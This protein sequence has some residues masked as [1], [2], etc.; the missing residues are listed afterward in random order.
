[1]NIDKEKNNLIFA[2]DIGTRSLIG[3]VGFYDNDHFHILDS[4]MIFHKERAMYD[5]QIHDIDGVAKSVENLKKSM[6]EKLNLT[7]DKVAIAAAGRALKTQR[8]IVERDV[9]PNLEIDSELIENLEVEGLQKAQS[10]LDESLNQKDAKY[11]CV[12]FS[13]VNYFLDDNFIESLKGHKGNKIGADIIATFLPNV[14]VDSLYTV[15]D[16]VN[17]EVVNMTLEPIAAINV[18]IKKNMRL[19]NLAMVDIGAGTS[20]IAITN[21]GSITAYAMVPSA[22]DK[23]TEDISMKYLLDFDTAENLKVNLNKTDSQKFIDIVG[24]EHDHSTE[25]ILDTIDEA[26]KDLAKKI[27]TEI[28][29]Y[30]EKAPSAV[31]LI[32]GGS[33][34]PRLTNY[35]AEFLN[36]PKERVVVKDSSLAD[37]FD[38][39][40][41]HLQGPDSITPLGIA[42]ATAKK[43]TNNFLEVILNGKKISLFN[44]KVLK[45][46]DVLVLSGYNPRS[47]IPQRGEDLECFVNQEKLTFKGSLGEAAK[48]LINGKESNLMSVIKNSDNIKITSATRGNDA[49]IKLFDCINPQNSIIFDKKEINLIKWIQVNKKSINENIEIRNNDIIEIKFLKTISDL[50]EYL[51]LEKVSIFKGDEELSLDYELQNNDVLFSMEKKSFEDETQNIINSVEF[52]YDENSNDSCE[53]ENINSYNDLIEKNIEIETNISKS[54]LTSTIQEPSINDVSCEGLYHLNIFVNNE[55]IKISHNKPN[56]IFIDIFDYIDFDRSRAKGFLKLKLN[57][58]TANY[59]QTLK[60]NDRVEIYWE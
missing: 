22:G 52:D 57:S 53:S 36:L 51:N 32:G 3:V 27:S 4:Q 11:Y 13:V 47:L 60:N 38:Q 6:E 42:L 2:L 29:Q 33:Q 48:I 23:I 18:A 43:N 25:E 26:I 21:K 5:G 56:F 34:I 30:N 50:L 9:D 46:S 55:P 54:L 31:F 40:P 28:I 58:K 12:G 16:R 10:L 35:I 7:L 20:D 19:L 1:M 8:I 39:I 17:L 15:M 44:S 24:I 59:T 14:V 41:E 37:N 45:V 49:R